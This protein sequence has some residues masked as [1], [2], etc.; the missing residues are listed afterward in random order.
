MFLWFLPALPISGLP[1]E[2]HVL[3]L[4]RHRGVVLRS[5]CSG[6]EDFSL[7]VDNMDGFRMLFGLSLVC[8]DVLLVHVWYSI[9]AWCSF[10]GPPVAIISYFQFHIYMSS[11]MQVNAGFVKS[12]ISSLSRLNRS[13]LYMVFLA[14]FLCNIPTINGAGRLI[15]TEP[16]TY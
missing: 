12:P 9:F 15:C 13:C 16:K 2:P 6:V 10:V 14:S 1:V 11:H 8:L 4:W 3:R 7:N 5:S